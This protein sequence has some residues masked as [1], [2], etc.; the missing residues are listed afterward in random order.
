MQ[1]KRLIVVEQLSGGPGRILLML[2]RPRLNLLVLKLILLVDDHRVLVQ[3]C[4]G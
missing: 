1:G 3:L 4:K 2:D